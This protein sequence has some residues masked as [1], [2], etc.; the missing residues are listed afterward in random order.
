MKTV[1]G[2]I[3]MMCAAP[4]S[5]GSIETLGRLASPELIETSGIAAS[6]RQLNVVWGVNDSGHAPLLHA[7][8][9]DGADLGAIRIRGVRNF[10]WEDLASFVLNGIP[11]LLI[12]DTGD[13]Q[14][15]RSVSNLLVVVEPEPGV[16]GKYAGV[17]D[18]VA[19]LPFRYEDGPRDC[20]AVAVDVATDRV[21]LVSKRDIPAAVYEL[22]LTLVSGIRRPLIARRIASIDALPRPTVAEALE[23]PLLGP[24]RYQPTAIDIA[25]DG[26]A[27]AVMT[28]QNLYLFRHSSG[29]GWGD[30]LSAAPQVVPLPAL[31]QTESVAFM[32]DRIIVV[33]EGR[34]APVLSISPVPR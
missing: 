19:R 24:W 28:Y 9:T 3:L 31:S 2:L 33:A 29:Q 22:P 17:A 27:M 25:D 6:E 1:F 5:A 11:Y 30:S 12:A 15:R 10:D 4:A 21:L 26:A 18:I 14:A 16:D 23:S 8:A 20:E 34:A 13:N 32:D 7:F